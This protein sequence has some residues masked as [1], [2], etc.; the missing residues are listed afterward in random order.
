[1]ALTAS[2]SALCSLAACGED[3][4]ENPTYF[5]EIQPLL[6]AACSACHGA[7][8]VDPKVASFRLDR[9]VKDD[10]A[11]YDV[12]DYAQPSGDGVP[13]LQRVAVNREAPAMPPGKALSQRDRD[14]L[15][16][17][18]AQGAPKG[19]RANRLPAIER[20]APAEVSAV[21]QELTLSLRA[22]DDDRDG[23]IVELWAH[24]LGA[25]GDA[26]DLPVSPR[27]GAGQRELTIDTGSLASKRSYQLYAI[28]DDGHADDPA[29]NRTR[30]DVV[31]EVFVD[32]GLR[33]TA[34]LVR[35]LTPNGGETLIGSTTI[36]WSASDADAGD[37]LT[38]ELALVAVAADGTE[39]SAMP[40]AGAL[41][42]TGS[43]M[44]SIPSSIP[45][46][47]S[48]G[49]PQRYKVRVTARDQLGQPQNVRSD[50]SD[51]T[52][53]IAHPVATTLTWSDVRPVF[54]M[55]CGACHG[56]PARTGPLDYF[57]LDKY[58]AGDP[59]AP[60]T[61]DLGVYEVRQLVYQRMITTSQ[62]PPASSPQPS[63]ADRARVG[64][65]IL[66]GAPRG[67][68]AGARPAFTWL[69]PTAPDATPPAALQWRATD[70]E[71]LRSGRLEYARV[72]GNIAAGCSGANL[73]NLTWTLVPDPKA[74]V[75]LGGAVEWADSLAWTP[76][77]TPAGYYCV[78]GTA[79]DTEGQATSV[80]NAYGVR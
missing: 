73:G 3:L 34:P 33:G 40:L 66:G 41:P 64:S 51:A 2:L 43:F 68:S 50:L 42:N 38:L 31:P 56:E 9:Y 67:G 72:N 5:G 57:R 61:S 70:V 21:D 58:D 47:D 4:P 25:S 44:W 6:Q 48:S 69:S 54:T 17:W 53:T 37:T 46:T 39:T 32:H 79:T 77:S 30:A 78:R 35:L 74:D 23:L 19:T 55:Y 26:G 16:R 10:A 45:A 28:L 24:E 52:F 80:V 62:M 11:T 20:L 15:E 75:T 1:M 49:A 13:P 8:P 27:F 18:L 12:W 59:V 36:T 14:L 65:W 29:Q 22:W 60:V 71:G 76:P 7:D 63:S